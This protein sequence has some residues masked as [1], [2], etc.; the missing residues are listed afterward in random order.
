MSPSQYDGVHPGCRGGGRER[1]ER[2]GEKGDGEGE[3]D[4]GEKRESERG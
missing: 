3:T 2:K 4:E 1:W